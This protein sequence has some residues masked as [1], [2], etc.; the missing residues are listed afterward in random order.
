MA[1]ITWRSMAGNDLPDGTRLMGMAQQSMNGAF[2]G[3]NKVL[4]DREAV[5]TANNLAVRENQTQD[6]LAKIQ[7][8][9]SPAEYEAALKS[10]LVA[11]LMS[12]GAGVDRTAIRNAADARLGTLQQ[13][14]KVGLEMAD[15]TLSREARPAVAAA[16]SD[17]NITGKRDK[18]DALIAQYPSLANLPEVIQAGATGVRA[19]N[20]E[21]RAV[22]S[23]VRADQQFKD[24][25]LTSAVQR[26]SSAASAN[27]SRIN[28]ET[29][30]ENLLLSRE[31]R[32]ADVLANRAAA[33]MQGLKESGNSYADGGIYTGKPDQIE[34]LTKTMKDL[35]IGDDDGD[36]QKIIRRLGENLS[37]PMTTLGKDGKPVKA[38]V[39]LPFNTVMQAVAGASDQMSWGYGQGWANNVEDSLK[40]EL[41]KT[42]VTA[43]PDGQ[44]VTQSKYLDDLG[45]YEKTIRNRIEYPAASDGKKKVK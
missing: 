14:E 2:D 43:G 30:Q 24:N 25:L 20:T 35:G 26:D 13:R 34:K 29:A 12:K 21:Q 9:G 18:I 31:K 37:M 10:G 45:A 44:P 42:Y 41:S 36:R 8:F 19:F 28:A 6:A 32:A 4:K 17:A 1:A 40:K 7:Q 39:P 23:E 3:F 33:Q 11:D 15:A 5:D 38:Q 22:T 27:T 16:L